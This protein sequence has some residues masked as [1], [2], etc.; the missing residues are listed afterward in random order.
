M[1]KH[2]QI[3]ALHAWLFLIL[4]CEIEAKHHNSMMTLQALLILRK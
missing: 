1:H 3:L 4:K 2:T